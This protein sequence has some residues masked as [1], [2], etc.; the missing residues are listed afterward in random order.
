[1]QTEYLSL[2]SVRKDR[3]RYDN[4]RKRSGASGKS[5]PDTNLLR[6]ILAI[7]GE[8]VTDRDDTHRY[9]LLASSDGG[10]ISGSI[11]T[12]RDC[13]D[14]LLSLPKRHLIVGFSITYDVCK[15]LQFVKRKDLEYLWQ[16]GYVKL[17]EYTV[18]W[19][20]GKYI[21]IRKGK[22]SVH[23]Y[24]VFGFFQRS[25]V[26][27]LEEWNVGTP[28]QIERIR[29]MKASRSTFS[30]DSIPEILA[31]C[32]EECELLVQLVGKL[33]D[34]IIEG[35]IPIER[36][37]GAGAIAAAILKKEGVKKHLERVPPVSWEIPVMSAYFGGRFELAVSGEH[38]NVY[39]Y[40]IRSAYPF[41]LS[42]L[43]CQ[44][45]LVYSRYSGYVQSELALYRVT[46]NV[47]EESYWPPFPFRIE[48]TKQII[49]PTSGEGYYHSSEVHA[50]MRMYGD[51]ITIIE[52]WVFQSHCGEAGCAGQPFRFIPEYYQYRN[53]LKA[54]GS[55]AQLTIKLGL[56]A[57]Y[58]K[59]A[60][61]VGWGDK[62]PPYQ[63]FLLA[64][65]MTAGTR[66]MLLDAIQQAPEDILW[67]ATDGIVSRVPLDLPEGKGLGEWEHGTADM[68]FCVQSGIYEVTKGNEI[69]IR[70]RGFGK[71]ETSFDEIR[72]A[73]KRDPVYGSYRYTVR[74][75]V[76]L[77]SAL[78][79]QDFWA[80]FGKW[81]EVDRTINFCQVKRFPGEIED[82]R[83]RWLP[84]DKPVDQEQSVPFQPRAQWSDLWSDEVLDDM[85]D[86]EQP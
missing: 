4:G 80:H 43:P 41:I 18:R 76:G 20:P 54:R 26:D 46:W 47:P 5:R 29:T 38:R 42:G 30:E 65:M 16:H 50:A 58:G 63:S 60:Q 22:Q 14:Y 57:M 28:E 64:G 74:R 67:T 6:P 78:M 51:A 31:Y 21:T 70:S 2:E 15:W 79:R 3:K 86:G 11:L 1:M 25:F 71:R 34:A 68:V 35:G 39:T 52:S 8:G 61:G 40:D 53:E 37:Y 55:Q 44:T 45:H 49:W 59:T 9:I 72:A 69:T 24:D 77:G 32:L 27:S 56:N 36:W 23:I 75:F 73:Y 33:R 84:P 81:L 62:K 17:Q 82:G 10:Y 19:A 7:D 12:T 48:G 66:A 13:F 85:I 83:V